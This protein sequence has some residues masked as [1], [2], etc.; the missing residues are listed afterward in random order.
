M[1]DTSKFSPPDI[2]QSDLVVPMPGWLI[3]R[4]L[5]WMEQYEAL[6]KAKLALGQ[7]KGNRY[8]VDNLKYIHGA[9]V[10]LAEAYQKLGPLEENK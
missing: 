3:Y 4:I 7:P 8:L 10:A 2:E 1:I 6:M 9:I 5:R